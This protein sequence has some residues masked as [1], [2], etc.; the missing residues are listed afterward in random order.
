[1]NSPLFKISNDT[2]QITDPVSGFID[3]GLEIKTSNGSY[4]SNHASLNNQSDFN[5]FKQELKQELQQEQDSF[6]SKLTHVLDEFKQKFTQCENDFI[7]Y[8]QT[9]DVQLHELSSKCDMLSNNIYEIRD[10]FIEFSSIQNDNDKYVSNTMNDINTKVVDLRTELQTEF[11]SDFQLVQEELYDNKIDHDII[12]NDIFK[13]QNVKG[14]DDEF[15][16]G[17]E[18]V[19][20]KKILDKKIDEIDESVL[21]CKAGV[22][23]LEKGQDFI[24]KDITIMNSRVE[25]IRVDSIDF[26]KEKLVDHECALDKLSSTNSNIKSIRESLEQIKFGCII[27]P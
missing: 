5:E 13:L 11:Y 14:G 23:L 7:L 22:E 19:E 25:E 24:V 9:V 8:K 17:D 10:E 16:K 15:V 18:F 6:L 27:L 1:M 20:Y 21:I 12:K 26:I 3:S 4:P 2:L